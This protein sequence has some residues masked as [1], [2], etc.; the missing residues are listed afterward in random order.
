MCQGRTLLPEHLP[1][2]L[3]ETASSPAASR[4]SA[5]GP[6]STLEEVERRHIQAVLLATEWNV[7]R[8]AEI[9]GIHRNTLRRRSRE[10]GLGRPGLQPM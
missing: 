8:A 7:S 1:P 5:S 2:E 4:P 6:L 10:L 9:L 3:F